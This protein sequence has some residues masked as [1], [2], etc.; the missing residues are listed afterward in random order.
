[1]TFDQITRALREHVGDDCGLNAV[2]SFDCGADGVIRIDG[3]SR[4]NTVTN[5]RA[6]TDCTITMHTA[7]LHGLITGTLNPTQAFLTG[8]MKV[9]GDLGVA[10]R[11]QKVMA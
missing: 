6:A 2:L 10:L 4:P 8:R 5:D 7:D 3:R 1:M 11:M 9:S